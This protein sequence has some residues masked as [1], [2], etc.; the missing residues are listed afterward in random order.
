MINLLSETNDF[1][2]NINLLRKTDGFISMINLLSKTSFFLSHS[3]GHIM[4][5]RSIILW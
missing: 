5:S 2:K 3:L 4:D 1:I